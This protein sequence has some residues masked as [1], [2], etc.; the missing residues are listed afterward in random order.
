L[1]FI[2][3]PLV[4]KREIIF[5]F[6]LFLCLIPTIYL[7]LEKFII[8]EIGC[9]NREAEMQRWTDEV[10]CHM[11]VLVPEDLRGVYRD[12]PRVKKLLTERPG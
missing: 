6:L 3:S 9:E 2:Q 8:P 4:S 10:M 1:L 11:T 7:L 12:H 5:G